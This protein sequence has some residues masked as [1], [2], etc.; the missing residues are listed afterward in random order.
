[1]RGAAFWVTVLLPSVRNCQTH[2]PLAAYFD[3]T[4]TNKSSYCPKFPPNFA[5]VLLGQCSHQCVW[6]AAGLPSRWGHEGL[7]AGVPR[8]PQPETRSCRQA[9]PPPG[10][11]RDRVRALAGTTAARGPRFAPARRA[12]LAPGLQETEIETSAGAVPVPRP[13]RGAG[14]ATCALPRPREF[15][16]E[17]GRAAPALAASGRPGSTGSPGA[18]RVSGAGQRG[19]ELGGVWGQRAAR[20]EGGSTGERRGKSPDEMGRGCAAGAEAARPLLRSPCSSAGLQQGTGMRGV[21]A[22]QA[23]GCPQPPGRH[24]VCRWSRLMCS[25]CAVRGAAGQEGGTGTPPC[26]RRTS[27][28]CQRWQLVVCFI[29][30]QVIIRNGLATDIVD[31]SCPLIARFF[32]GIVFFKVCQ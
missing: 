30:P 31:I 28:H 10:T 22:G 20:R 7:W 13:R 11:R 14:G 26:W 24:R 29:L 25:T 3:L 21:V 9:L 19:E 8:C 17:P 5:E 4:A 32:K 16:A 27:Y 15:P 12:G 1:M 23:P 18:L 6:E 2:P